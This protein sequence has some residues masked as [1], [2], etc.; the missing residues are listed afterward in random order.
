MWLTAVSY[1][2]WLSTS[3][4]AVPQPRLPRPG[5]IPTWIMSGS[6]EET[7]ERQIYWFCAVD[8]FKRGV[9]GVAG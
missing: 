8:D 9:G 5:E 4:C 2:R 6:L 1:Q 3:P 7:A